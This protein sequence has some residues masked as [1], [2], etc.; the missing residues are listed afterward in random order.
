[1]KSTDLPSFD[2]KRF[3][4]TKLGA[5]TDIVIYVNGKKVNAKTLGPATHSTSQFGGATW[6]VDVKDCNGK[7]RLCRW[8]STDICTG[9]WNS[10]D[11]RM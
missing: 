4:H 11:K 7:R 1:M 2:E 9:K 10:L 8:I 3:A 5:N 6:Y